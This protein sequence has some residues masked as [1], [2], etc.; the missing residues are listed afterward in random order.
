[1]EFEAYKLH[2]T[3]REK[4]TLKKVIIEEGKGSITMEEAM[5]LLKWNKQ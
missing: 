3:S 1:M 4:V 2:H 5:K